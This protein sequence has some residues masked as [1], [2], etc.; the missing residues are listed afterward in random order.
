MLCKTEGDDSLRL[1]GEK[2]AEQQWNI[3]RSKNHKIS[4]VWDTLEVWGGVSLSDPQAKITFS[5]SQKVITR[6]LGFQNGVGLLRAAAC[7]G[8][9]RCGKRGGERATVT[10]VGERQEG[11]R[12][13][14]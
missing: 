4:S 14:A 13:Q 1:E 11:N 10:D 12:Y 3:S 5:T 8:R 6:P 9:D 7:C 2:K